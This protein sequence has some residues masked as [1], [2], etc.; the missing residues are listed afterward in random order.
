MRHLGTINCE[1][2]RPTNSSNINT[3][4][5]SSQRYQP[6]NAIRPPS[7]CRTGIGNR[8]AL[9]IQPPSVLTCAVPS[10]TS[11]GLA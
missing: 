2:A 10:D 1:G 11:G 3:V 4:A 6:L 5:P 9:V 7:L 8:D